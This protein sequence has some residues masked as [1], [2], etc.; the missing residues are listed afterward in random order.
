MHQRVPRRVSAPE[1]IGTQ[2]ER[3]TAPMF[4]PPPEMMGLHSYSG[5]RPIFQGNS[6]ERN[7]SSRPPLS[8]RQETPPMNGAV[9]SLHGNGSFQA[10]M[11]PSFPFNS[12]NA[13]TDHASVPSV[14]EMSLSGSSLLYHAVSSGAS[15]R[16]IQSIVDVDPTSTRHQNSGGHTALHCGIERYDTPLEVIRILIE[17][18]PAAA[19]LK[20]CDGLTPVDLI[21]KRYVSP[22]SYRSEYAKNAAARLRALMEN[23]VAH[24]SV[25]DT[26]QVA[27]SSSKMSNHTASICK[28]VRKQ[29]AKNALETDNEFRRFWDLINLAIRAA[30]RGTCNK[31]LHEENKRWRIVHEAVTANC[32]PLLIR[33][34]AALHPEQLRQRE[35]K[36][37]RLPLHLAAVTC[38]STL[39]ETKTITQSLLCLYPDAAS[40]QDCN[41]RLPINLALENGQ[42]WEGCVREMFMAWPQSLSMQDRETRLVPFMLSAVGQD[43]DINIIFSL[44]R[45]GPLEVVR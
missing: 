21:W 10:Q 14:E 7:V 8:L 15:P 35:E 22:E 2:E 45:E 25:Q 43:S 32:P 27:S 3:D 12:E 36:Y 30:N 5:E 24:D 26:K 37:G 20:N 42:P 17:A 39:N 13:G 44:L 6:S 1:T 23:I 16:V 34:A 28:A 18:N 41:G 33:F 9:G 38:R 40:C 31:S 11:P 4:S 29:K 19:R